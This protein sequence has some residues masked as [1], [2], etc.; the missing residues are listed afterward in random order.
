MSAAARAIADRRAATQIR[1]PEEPPPPPGT[2]QRGVDGGRETDNRRRCSK[3]RATGGPWKRSR[4]RRLLVLIGHSNGAWPVRTNSGSKPSSVSALMDGRYRSAGIAP[5]AHVVQLGAAVAEN[6]TSAR[7]RFRRQAPFTRRPPLPE[8][9][10]GR[11]PRRPTPGSAGRAVSPSTPRS[12]VRDPLF[13]GIADHD[14]SFTFRA[15]GREARGDCGDSAAE[16]AR[17][18]LMQSRGSLREK[19]SRNAANAEPV[20]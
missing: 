11:P 5:S 8:D 18:F 7:W 12:Y 3:A 9:R 14:G 10:A 19:R 17:F 13:G 6:E 16:A 1:R 4:L 15:G 20:M 2:V